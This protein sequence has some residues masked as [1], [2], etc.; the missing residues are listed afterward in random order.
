VI[1]RSWIILSGRSQVLSVTIFMVI[2]NPLN[3]LA[4]R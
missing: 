2:D 3:V 4:T 1:S